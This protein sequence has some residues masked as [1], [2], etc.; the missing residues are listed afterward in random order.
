MDFDESRCGQWQWDAI[1]RARHIRD[2]VQDWATCDYIG[3]RTIASI[4]NYMGLLGIRGLT[5][6]WQD[7]MISLYSI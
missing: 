1:S 3:L 4:D 6:I 7:I 5:R 2:N